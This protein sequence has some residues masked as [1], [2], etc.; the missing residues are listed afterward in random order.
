MI[1]WNPF[2]QPM[3]RSNLESWVKLCDDIVKV[4]LI[5]MPAAVYSQSL[6]AVKVLNLF[7]LHFQP[8][9]V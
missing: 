6:L 3:K 8:M 7:Y 2:K 4:S 5:A 1:T 9:L